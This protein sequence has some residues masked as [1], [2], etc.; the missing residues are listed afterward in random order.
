[1]TFRERLADWISGGALTFHQRTAVNAL[2]EAQKA[3][4]AL[5][6]IKQVWALEQ[7]AKL[8]Q[9]WDQHDRHPPRLDEYGHYGE[10]NPPVEKPKP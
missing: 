7:M 6:K 10:N 8:G 2:A 9:E 3:R 4:E 1:M 5:I